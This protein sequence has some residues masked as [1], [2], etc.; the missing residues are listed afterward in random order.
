MKKSKLRLI[1]SI[2]IL[3]I[4]L[5]LFPIIFNLKNIIGIGYY[6]KNKSYNISFSEG[7]C[8]I[9]LEFILEHEERYVNLGTFTIQTT[10]SG[11]LEQIGIIYLK[12]IIKKDST[13]SA[14]VDD[15]KNP[16]LK[17]YT[18]SHKIYHLEFDDKVALRGELDIAFNYNGLNY[19]EKIIFEILISI[20][21][22]NDEIHYNWEL[23][24]IW[25]IT[26][27]FISI[28]VVIFIIR[29][30]YLTIKHEAWYTEEEKKKDEEFFEKIKLNEN[31]DKT[32]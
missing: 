8:S 31:V 14:Y 3:V 27:Y 24:F 22:G 19:I 17:S 5:A 20:T 15:D 13:V 9:D 10:S 30:F 32:I 26:F 7:S 1:V 18:K 16:P 29:R 2:I 4:L 28:I 23:P 11:N 21:I 12:Y 6:H 25:I